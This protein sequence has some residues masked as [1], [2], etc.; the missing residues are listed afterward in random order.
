MCYPN[1][2]PR[3]S[4]HTRVHL[5]KAQTVFDAIAA[6]NDAESIEYL[7]AKALLNSAKSAYRS[8]PDG[9]KQLTNDVAN[10]PE[11]MDKKELAL[12]K[13]TLNRAVTKREIQKNAY[14]E[15]NNGRLDALSTLIAS[16]KKARFD[17]DET[18][19]I[20]QIH[21]STFAS[22]ELSAV[23][24]KL[25]PDEEAYS[26]FIQTMEDKF[27]NGTTE[28]KE[29]LAQ[30]KALPAP[31]APSLAAYTSIEEGFQKSQVALTVEEARIASFH[32]ISNTD[33]AAYY[34]AYRTQYQEE[35]ANLKQSER[36]DPPKNWTNNEIRNLSPNTLGDYKY[37]PKDAA[38]SY[39]AYRLRSDASSV[40]GT[41][42]AEA[43]YASIDLETAGP[44]GSAGFKPSNGHII[45]V[46]IVKYNNKGQEISRYSKLMRPDQAFLDEHGTGAEH[47]HQIS[48]KDLD[49]QPSWNSVSSEVAAELKGTVFIA[50]N[51]NFEQA[52]LGEHLPGFQHN[53]GQKPVIDT[54]DMSRRHFDI[55]NHRLSTICEQVGVAY[56]NGHRATHDAE[57][58]GQAFFKFRSIIQNQWNS[59]PARRN[60]KTVTI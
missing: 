38:S 4:R 34:A 60:A 19:S 20:L 54:L 1:P 2:G 13:K 9:I 50:Q 52:W 29:A 56:T 59:K 24:A 46:G 22:K 3:C 10:A 23:K 18:K 28:Q 57:V 32:N 48:V 25:N 44:T 41:N 55:Q 33:S 35:Y 7:N 58:T 6:D 11:D 31:D 45:E 36:P 47:I 12:L 49:N 26:A 30:L 8:S 16:D 53:T 21:T 27:G 43:I 42:Q 17:E 5:Q 14:V 40:K 15:M 51:A 37:L 39:A